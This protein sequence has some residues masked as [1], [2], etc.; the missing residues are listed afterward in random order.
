MIETPER[1]SRLSGMT[2][3]DRQNV[4]DPICH[5]VVGKVQ[6]HGGIECLAN[7]IF[8][9]AVLDLYEEW[10]HEIYNRE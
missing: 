6:I 10:Q 1:Y 2:S 8:A 5:S 4:L 3:E 7:R 9:L